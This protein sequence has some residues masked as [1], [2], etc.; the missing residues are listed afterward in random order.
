MLRA[1]RRWL[2]RPLLFATFPRGGGHFVARSACITPRAIMS[3]WLN[4]IK[5]DAPEAP[6]EPNA[7]SAPTASSSVTK[8]VVDTNAI[9]KGSDS[10]A[11]PTRR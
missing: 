4:A 10:S 11:S 2:V 8:V 6:V 9:V 1:R 3:G 5:T 7:P